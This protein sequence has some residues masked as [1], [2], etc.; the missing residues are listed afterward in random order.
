MPGYRKLSM[1]W[2]KPKREAGSSIC[3]RINV[4]KRMDETESG[5]NSR[6]Q[7]NT[8]KRHG[9]HRPSVRAGVSKELADD[10]QCGRNCISA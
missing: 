4:S 1:L 8:E 3:R 9:E 6:I 7:R 2:V 10:L 5:R